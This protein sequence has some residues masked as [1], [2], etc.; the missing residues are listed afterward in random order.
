MQRCKEL[1]TEKRDKGQFFIVFLSA[2][3][4]HKRER[5]IRNRIAWSLLT[6]PPPIKHAVVIHPFQLIRLALSVLFVCPGFKLNEISTLKEGFFTKSIN[7]LS[8]CLSLE[9][10]VQVHRPECVYSSQVCLQHEELRRNPTQVIPNPHDPWIRL[11]LL[12]SNTC[13]SF[14]SLHILHLALTSLLCLFLLG[15][16]LPGKFFPH[17][18]WKCQPSTKCKALWTIS[19]S[20]STFCSGVTYFRWVTVL[21]LHIG[22][23]CFSLTQGCSSLSSLSAPFWDSF[24]LLSDAFLHSINPFLLMHLH[25]GWFSSGQ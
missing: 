22:S 15:L 1:S 10:L 11:V 19:N 7:G 18:S 16:P 24:S 5:S 8:E 20:G 25:Y 17:K 23:A 6:L 14:S 2:L 12:L 9:H 3:G 21:H 4:Q 13:T